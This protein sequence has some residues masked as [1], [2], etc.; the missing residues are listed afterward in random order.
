[1]KVHELLEAATSVEK[2]AAKYK[3]ELSRRDGAII[4][5]R[6]T[7]KFTEKYVINSETGSWR[8]EVKL[9]DETSGIYY[10][11]DLERF[12]SHISKKN[13]AKIEKLQKYFD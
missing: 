1:M 2:M 13:R 6:P 5:Q 4:L 9:G 12:K 8:Y 11:E 10:G 7:G 3:F